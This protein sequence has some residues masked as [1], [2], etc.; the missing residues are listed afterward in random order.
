MRWDREWDQP[1]QWCSA[2]LQS[3]AVGS[4]A[5]RSFFRSQNTKAVG[6]L[7]PPQLTGQQ[8]HF[9]LSGGN[10]WCF[11]NNSRVYLACKAGAHKCHIPMRQLTQWKEHSPEA[12]RKP[13][14]LS[15]PR[16]RCTHG[17]DIIKASTSGNEK[18][19]GD[20]RLGQVKG[21]HESEKKRDVSNRVTPSPS[22]TTQCLAKQTIKIN[23]D[24]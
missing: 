1:A 10:L 3:R 2:Y 7:T 12:L 4:F 5:P 15:H 13:M 8:T 21:H 14:K 11:R 16:R 23:H 19:Q 17:C 9:L 20:H 22:H 6:H 24:H 18:K